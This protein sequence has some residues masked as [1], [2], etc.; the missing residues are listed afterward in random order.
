MNQNL[1]Q[2]P[3]YTY[4]YLRKEGRWRTWITGSAHWDFGLCLTKR[5]TLK[6]IL[7]I[8]F[9]TSREEKF[10]LHHLHHFWENGICL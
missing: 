1:A 9:R 5:K 6:L 2:K 4:I 10:V 7:A 3:A 8:K